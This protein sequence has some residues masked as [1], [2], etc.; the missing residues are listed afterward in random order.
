MKGD[1]FC[2]LKAREVCHKTQIPASITKLKQSS[3]FNKECCLALTYSFASHPKT[4]QLLTSKQHEN[5]DGTTKS[6]RKH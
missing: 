2:V 4:I 6:T 3:D 5:I 1:L